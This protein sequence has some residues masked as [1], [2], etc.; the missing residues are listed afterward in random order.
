[1]NEFIIYNIIVSET[2]SKFNALSKFVRSESTAVILMFLLL[3]FW[4]ATTF[5]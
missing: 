5:T 2:W 3:V 1:M 4:F